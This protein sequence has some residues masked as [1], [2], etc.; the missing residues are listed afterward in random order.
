MKQKGESDALF[1]TRESVV[2]FMERLLR[3]KMFHRAKVVVV[4]KSADTKKKKG[5][6]EES[7][8]D[9]PSKKSKKS[10]ETVVDGDESEKKESEKKESEKKRK[11]KKGKK[12]IKLDMHMEQIFVDGKEVS[13]T[14]ESN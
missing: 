14:D 3:F 8:A 13:F 4:Q 2:D 12:K 6:D 5:G 9:E 11:E 7:A 10:K 1:T